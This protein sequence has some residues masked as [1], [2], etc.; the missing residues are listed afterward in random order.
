MGALA[1]KPPQ[2]KKG[3]DDVGTRAELT[4]I[5]YKSV[6]TPQTIIPFYSAVT[7]TRKPSLKDYGF[8]P[9]GL[10]EKSVNTLSLGHP[11]KEIRKILSFS[12]F[13]GD[14]VWL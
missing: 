2:K 6:T 12:E 14:K 11:R 8:M 4:S 5:Q 10:L 1:I 3:K 7:I 9:L 13:K